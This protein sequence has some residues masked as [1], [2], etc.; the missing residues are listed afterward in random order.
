MTKVNV[1]RE[2]NPDWD[3][4]NKNE[5]LQDKTEPSARQQKKHVSVNVELQ[6]RE[7]PLWT[8]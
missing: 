1:V 8:L 7:W 6:Y 3:F 5:A 2:K 4:K